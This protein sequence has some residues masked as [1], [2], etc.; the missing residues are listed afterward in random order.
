MSHRIHILGASGSGATTLGRHLAK[1]LGGIHLDADDYYWLRTNPPFT[2]KRDSAERVALIEHDIRTE[3]NWVL[4]GSICSWGDPLL[5][6]FTLAIFLHLDPAT[7]MARIAKRESARY[8]SRSL[9]HETFLSI[10]MILGLLV[11]VRLCRGEQP[12]TS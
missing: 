2:D 8:G 10:V 6:R 7:R 3:P 4:S 5:E 11:A 1:E 12:S 9:G